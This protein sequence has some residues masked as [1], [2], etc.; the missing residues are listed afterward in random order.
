MRKKKVATQNRS[1]VA[2]L[3]DEPKLDMIPMGMHKSMNI[4][5]R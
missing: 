4:Q 3:L 1:E 2:I 5:A